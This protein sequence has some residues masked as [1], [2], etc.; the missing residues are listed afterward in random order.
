MGRWGDGEMGRWGDGEMGRWGGECIDA[1]LARSLVYTLREAALRL[2]PLI[3]SPA[4]SL[5]V[6]LSFSL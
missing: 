4:C 1:S 3:S 6:S 5:P 2:H